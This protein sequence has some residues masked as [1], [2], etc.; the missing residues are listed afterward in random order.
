M[1]E[2][3]SNREVLERFAREIMHMETKEQIDGFINSFVYG[4]LCMV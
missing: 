4:I 2:K 1:S 3:V